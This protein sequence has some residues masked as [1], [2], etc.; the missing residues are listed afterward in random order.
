MA[1]QAMLQCCCAVWRSTVTAVMD[2]SPSRHLTCKWRLSLLKQN[3]DSSVN[4]ECHLEF[5]EALARFNLKWR[6]MCSSYGVFST[7]VR[8]LWSTCPD[9]T[10]LTP[11]L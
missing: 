3:H 9:V 1:P 11:P 5:H 6:G 10:L 2:L 7:S 8:L 4:T